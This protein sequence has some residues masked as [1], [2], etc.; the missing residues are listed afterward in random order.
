M[1]FA[2]AFDRGLVSGLGAVGAARGAARHVE[3][4]RK[5]ASIGDLEADTKAMIADMVST[6]CD[7]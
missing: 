3:T 2:V 4:M 5:V 6:G 7:R 1:L